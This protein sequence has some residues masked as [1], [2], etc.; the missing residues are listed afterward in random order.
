[1]SGMVIRGMKS[2]GIVSVLSRLPADK[3]NTTQDHDP[4]H[5]HYRHIDLT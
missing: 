1:V 5:T 2:S 4:Q 3:M